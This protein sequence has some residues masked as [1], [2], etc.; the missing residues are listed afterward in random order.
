MGP[1]EVI[2]TKDIKLAIVTSKFEVT[3]RKALQ[4]F[5]LEKFF[6]CVIGNGQVQEA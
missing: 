5:N 2:L 1:K 4:L 3:A 6:S